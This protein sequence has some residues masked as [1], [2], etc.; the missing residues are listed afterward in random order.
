MSDRFY[1]AERATNLAF[2]DHDAMLSAAFVAMAPVDLGSADM[3]LYLVSRWQLP[4]RERKR[5]LNEIV[6]SLD[7]IG[8]EPE[9]HFLVLKR[10]KN[11]TPYQTS[12]TKDTTGGKNPS[13]AATMVPA[14]RT[15]AEI[16]APQ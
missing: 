8:C 3:E 14:A 2:G 11:N 6:G 12:A 4:P 5:R 9:G 10:S 16:R 15:S 1:Q 13:H 7:Y